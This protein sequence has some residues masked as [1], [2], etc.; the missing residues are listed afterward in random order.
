MPHGPVCVHVARRLE[1]D[2]RVGA[3]PTFPCT[4]AVVP[5]SHGLCS[6]SFNLES[7]VD[8]VLEMV[9]RFLPRLLEDVAPEVRTAAA[10]CVCMVLHR[11]VAPQLARSLHELHMSA[12]GGQ[13]PAIFF[14]DESMPSSSAHYPEQL[15]AFSLVLDRA[16]MVGVADAE[17]DIRYTVFKSLTPAADPLVLRT[18]SLGLLYQAINDESFAVREAVMGVVSRLAHRAPLSVMPVVRKS[19]G[20]QMEQLEYSD[21]VRVKAEAINLLKC[22]AHGAG[23]LLEPYVPSIMQH[24][25][26]QLMDPAASPSV[27]QVS[28]TAPPLWSPCRLIPSSCAAG[29]LGPPSQLRWLR[30][31]LWLR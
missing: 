8:D 2:D 4:F 24:M 15:E 6:G 9:N 29:H 23:S 27:V 3:F 14:S 26:R 18:N 16:I 7:R 28:A 5:A 1:T 20:E 19:I 25:L 10:Q 11:F 22:L 17:A 21:D 30:R 13:D 31:L 12:A